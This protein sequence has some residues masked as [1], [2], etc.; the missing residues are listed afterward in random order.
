MVDLDTQKEN[1]NEKKHYKKGKKD[2]E[3]QYKANEAE[4]E[5]PTEET[6]YMLN[7]PQQHV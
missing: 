1:E 2:E 7:E 6:K 4:Q 3:W 5:M